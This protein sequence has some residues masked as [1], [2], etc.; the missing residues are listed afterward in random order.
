V[1]IEHKHTYKFFIPI[2]SDVINYKND[3]G[4]KQNSTR[5]TMKQGKFSMC[6]HVQLSGIS[7]TL[8][9]DMIRPILV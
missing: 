9:Y 7:G 8:S 4:K 5:T 2:V 3:E 6:G 1:G